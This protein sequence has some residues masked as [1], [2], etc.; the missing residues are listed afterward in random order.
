V[1]RNTT[2][3]ERCADLTN[4]NFTTDPARRNKRQPKF[5]WLEIGAQ[6]LMTEMSRSHRRLRSSRRRAARDLPFGI[7][8]KP[9]WG[10]FWFD[11]QPGVKLDDKRV[12]RP[13]EGQ[14]NSE[15]TL[16][17]TRDFLVSTL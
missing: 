16:R 12:Y 13:V 10:Q 2:Q 7:A 3:N 6:F 11:D 4:E 9:V 15:R 5:V 14:I 8:H 17:P 1:G